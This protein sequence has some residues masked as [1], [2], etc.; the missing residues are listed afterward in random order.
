M[1]IQWLVYSSLLGEKGNSDELYFYIFF[2]CYPKCEKVTSAIKF[3][4]KM[5]QKF[6]IIMKKKKNHRKMFWKGGCKYITEYIIYIYLYI[7]LNT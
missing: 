2:F 4:T 5:G 7:N 3:S 1:Y 6:L